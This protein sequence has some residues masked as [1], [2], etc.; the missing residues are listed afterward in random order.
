MGN[1]LTFNIESSTDTK[2]PKKRKKVKK[3]VPKL[4]NKTLTEEQLQDKKLYLETKERSFFKDIKGFKGFFLRR[5]KKNKGHMHVLVRMIMYSGDV[6]EFYVPTSD[7]GFVFDKR[8]YL[9][10]DSHRYFN[11]TSQCYCY[12]FHQALDIPIRLR[13]KLPH[14]MI[15]FIE[16]H[17]KQLSKNQ[18]AKINAD[19]IK[20]ILENPDVS[21]VDSSI[22]PKSLE[23][24]LKSNFVQALVMAASI[25]RIFRIILILVI[26]TLGLVVIDVLIDAWASGMFENLTN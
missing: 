18:S 25:G 15:Q 20:E 22:N 1:K 10:D 13:V 17:E 24:Y 4:L 12:D 14:E 19:E 11:P 8:R 2:K 3:A 23:E 7:K 26:I 9:F 5:R 6:M 16:K 21:D